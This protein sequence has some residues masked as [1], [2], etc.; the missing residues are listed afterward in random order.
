MF[1]NRIPCT[2]ADVYTDLYARGAVVFRHQAPCHADPGDSNRFRRFLLS[3]CVADV[4][5]R[6][7]RDTLPD[8]VLPAADS[9]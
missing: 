4:P 7:Q 8:T 5:V 9:R 2:Q 6:G 3:S 1:E